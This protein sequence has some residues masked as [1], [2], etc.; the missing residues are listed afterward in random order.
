M[1]T[2]PSSVAMVLALHV[3][4]NGSML[5]GTWTLLVISQESSL[6]QHETRVIFISWCRNADSDI[7][8]NRP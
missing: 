5:G 6:H 8:S 2:P 4:A 3:F 7:S 1:A